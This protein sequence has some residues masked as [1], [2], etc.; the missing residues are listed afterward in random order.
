MPSSG[1]PKIP[2]DHRASNCQPAAEHQQQCVQPIFVVALF[3]QKSVRVLLVKDH[4]AFDHQQL[5]AERTQPGVQGRVPTKA[6]LDAI[7]GRVE[8]ND[9][10]HSML[11]RV[12][13]DEQ[14]VPR[15]QRKVFL[16]LD[17]LRDLLF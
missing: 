3:D 17:R 2:L 4:D 7:P 12:D 13:Y 6:R 1:L 9:G 8:A 10:N 5:V 11:Q 16:F 15:Q 14:I